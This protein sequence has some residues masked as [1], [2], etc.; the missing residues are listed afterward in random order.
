MSDPTLLGLST[1]GWTVLA[2]AVMALVAIVS[3]WVGYQLMRSQDRVIEIQSGLTELQRRANWLNGALESH[4][5]AMLR[6]KAG[7]LGK[8]V[9]WWDPTHDG[10]KK[11]RPP[12]TR[13]HGEAAVLDDPVYLYVPLEE[14]RYPDIA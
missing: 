14:R 12:R 10:Q 4:S 7:E 6:M 11:Q 8:Q 3:A 9:I 1:A 13:V 5:A 2:K